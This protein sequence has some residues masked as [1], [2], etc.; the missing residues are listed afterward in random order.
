MN[1]KG[2][3]RLFTHLSASAYVVLVWNGKIRMV[4]I[5]R[6]IFAKLSNVDAIKFV[7]LSKNFGRGTKIVRRYGVLS[8]EEIAIELNDLLLAYDPP[9]GPPGVYMGNTKKTKAT[10]AKGGE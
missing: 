4:P 7:A 9:I 2:L 3:F 6:A 5:K 1:K 10:K 8:P